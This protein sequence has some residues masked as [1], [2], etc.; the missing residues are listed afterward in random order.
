MSDLDIAISKLVSGDLSLVFVKEGG[1]IY[2]SIDQGLKPFISALQTSYL[3]LKGSSS[4][5]KVIGRAAALLAVYTS[6]HSVFASTISFDAA[7]VLKKHNIPFSYGKMVKQIMNQSNTG[8][9]PFEKA[10]NDTDDP[11]EA[12]RRIKEELYPPLAKQ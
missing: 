9:C 2:Q 4:A 5:D 7:K 1:V 10:V 8:L 3:N 12:Y 6:I 11:E